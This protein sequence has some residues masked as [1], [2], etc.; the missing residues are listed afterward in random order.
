MFLRFRSEWPTRKV[1]APEFRSPLWG[2][3]SVADAFPEVVAMY[4]DRE[5]PQ[6]V[7]A[8]ILRDLER[9]MREYRERNGVWGFNSLAW[10][11]NHVTSLLFELGSLQFAPGKWRK[12]FTDIR[13]HAICC[14]TWLLD[15]A[16]EHVLPQT[17]N[18]LAFGRL[19]HPLGGPAMTGFC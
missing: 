10:M 19:F 3:L 8:G 11:R 9:R 14:R 5:F 18:I 13:F 1:E 4:A 12:I 17:S 15:R 16:L 2:A 6:A 7:T